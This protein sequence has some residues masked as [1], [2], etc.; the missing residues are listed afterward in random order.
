MYQLN[1]DRKIFAHGSKRTHTQLISARFLNSTGGASFSPLDI[2]KASNEVKLIGR[3]TCGSLQRTHFVR[4][5]IFGG[6]SVTPTKRAVQ[7]CCIPS[8]VLRQDQI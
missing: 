6:G 3:M 1:H 2:R 7:K 8:N 5:L 4:L